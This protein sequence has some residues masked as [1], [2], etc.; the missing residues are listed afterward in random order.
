MAELLM[1]EQ[2]RKT[3]FLEWDDA[4]LGR[5]VKAAALVKLEGEDPSTMPGYTKVTLNACC[6]PLIAA[7]V[8]ANSKESVVTIE[9][10]VDG[11]R[12]FGDW[13]VIVRRKGTAHTKKARWHAAAMKLFREQAITISMEGSC[14]SLNCDNWNDADAMFSWL[15]AINGK[16]GSVDEWLDEI[17]AFST[18]RERLDD[19][20]RLEPWLRAAF[21]AGCT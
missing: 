16:Y 20:S 8:A 15:T 7:A 4:N 18:R 6:V 5:A 3:P 12:H 9:G 1:S 2:E 11:D 14:V 19:T 10:A 17:E 13:E 21:D